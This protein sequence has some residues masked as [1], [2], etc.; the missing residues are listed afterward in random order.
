MDL[1]LVIMHD[2]GAH[3][4]GRGWAINLLLVILHR[5]PNSL[6]F[7]PMGVPWVVSW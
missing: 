3:L 7:R 4:R 1:L 2:S 5:L 6:Q